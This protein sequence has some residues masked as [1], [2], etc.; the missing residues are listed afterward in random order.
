VPDPG[1]WADSDS[2]ACLWASVAL[3]FIWPKVTSPQHPSVIP[4][5][6]V[7]GIVDEIGAGCLLFDVGD[8]VG[9]PWLAHTC[10]VCRFCAAAAREPLCYDTGVHRAGTSTGA[11]RNMRW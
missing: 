3:I 11:T 10:G 8:R 9:V 1:T 4:G 6:E 5:H 2:R 7:V